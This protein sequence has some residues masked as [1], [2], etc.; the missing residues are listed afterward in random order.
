MTVTEISEARKLQPAELTGKTWRIKIIEGDR[1]GTS[2]YYPKEVVEAGKHLF[3]KG[4]RSFKNHPSADEKWNRPERSIDDIVGYL[5]ESAEYDGKDLWANLT[6]VESERERIKEL[7]EAGLID[8][9]IRAAGEMV[10]GTNGMELKK[11]VAVHSVDIVTQGGAGGQFG[12]MLES[13]RNQISASESG[14]EPLEEKEPIKMDKELEAALSALIE[15]TNKTAE[16][17]NTLVEAKT[18]EDAD[19]E[20]AL[21]EAQK[22]GEPKAPSAA[23]IAGALVEAELPKAAHAKVIAAVESGTELAE[24]ISAEKKYLETIVE[25][26]GKEFRGNGSEELQEAAGAKI[27]ATM[28]GD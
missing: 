2:A 5:S 18:K 14:A 15:T 22:A 6:I 17:V 12:E 1:Q 26:S 25:E 16:A 10:E 20:A 19:K 8:I 4:V 23:E 9:S 27:G 3:G 7:A 21:V 24:A 11:F 13:A 28:F